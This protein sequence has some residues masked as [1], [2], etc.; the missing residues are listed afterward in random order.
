MACPPK[1]EPAPAG[2]RRLS[3]LLAEQQEPFSLDAYLL[4]KGYPE[5]RLPP[6]LCWSILI[7][8][9]S[10]RFQLLKR[11]LAEFL[12]LKA[13]S[14][15]NDNK[16]SFVRSVS[17][18][19]SKNGTNTIE[20]DHGHLCGS[21]PSLPWKGWEVERS[22]VSVLDLPSS[23]E[24][25]SCSCAFFSMA[26]EDEAKD[27]DGLKELLESSASSPAGNSLTKSRKQ[28]DEPKKLLPDYEQDDAASMITSIN[29]LTSSTISS[30]TRREWYALQPHTREIGTHVE[31]AIF[32]DIREAVILEMI[33]FCRT[34]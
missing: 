30:G 22:P 27:F 32:E 10:S 6:P 7:H 19:A 5:R 1:P 26:D 24:G 20:D 17:D 33:S 8:R 31:E 14:R 4:Q 18:A 13:L 2:V 28:L 9:R 29:Q 21:P 3:E 16:K 34:L 15:E 25:S 23:E 12:H 11:K